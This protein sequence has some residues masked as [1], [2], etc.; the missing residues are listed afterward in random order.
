MPS[1]DE[2]T[3]ATSGDRLSI[4]LAGHEGAGTSKVY[5]GAPDLTLDEADLLRGWRLDPEQWEIIDGTLRVN[6][7]VQNAEADLWCHQYK[8]QV[9]KRIPEL[10]D[11][12]PLVRVK[13]TVKRQQARRVDVGLACAVI[14][15]DAQISYWRDI[16]DVWRT[17]HDERALDISRQ[18]LADV[19]AAHGVDVVV[20]LGDFLDATSFSKHRSQAAFADR[21]AFKRSVARGQQELAARTALAPDAD[22]W[23]IPGNHENRITHWLTDNA[24]FLLGLQ[25]PGQDPVLSLEWLLQT[26]EHGWQI[27]DAY[28]EGAVYLSPNLR[29]IHGTIAKGRPGQTAGEYLAEEVNTIAGHHP[30]TQTAY[31]TVAR[32][33]HTRTYVAHLPSGLM[34]VDGAVP[35]ATTGSTIQGDPVLGKGEK[36]EQGVSVVFYDPDGHT[37]PYIEHVP[38]FDG[39]A[40]WRGRVYESELDVDGLA[41]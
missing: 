18:V 41:A 9:R 31:R 25:M 7:W 22:R 39:K 17:S 23:L 3:A 30:R 32:H 27:A 8:A 10:E 6:R 13:V 12:P 21:V 20:D 2:H 37:V 19:Q 1:L 40:V 36:W 14:F 11:I 4:E 24:P 16:D 15:P 34:R 33:G 29:C 5:V 38:I 26:E 28:P 35:S